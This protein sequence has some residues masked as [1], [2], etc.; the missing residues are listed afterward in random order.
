MLNRHDYKMLPDEIRTACREGRHHGPTAHLAPGFVQ[1]NL[2]IVP[3]AFAEDFAGFCAANAKACPLLERLAPGSPFTKR[4]AAHADVR[5]DLPGYRIFTRGERSDVDNIRDRFT[6]DATAFLLGCSFSFEEGLKEAGIGVRHVELGCNVPM[7][8]TTRDVHGVGPFCG[9]HVVSMRPIPEALLERAY[10]AT[11]PYA[12]VHGEPV[13]HGDPNALGIADLAD[14]DYGDAVPLYPGEVPVFWACGVTSQEAVEGAVNRGE[15]P[16]AI[17]HQP[18][19][20][21][22]G[23]LCVETLKIL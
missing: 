5:C 9:K 3:E 15:L 13:H 10:A 21:F 22:V 6:A 16:W 2:V 20:M 17:T 7:Y 23:D 18:G 8:R 14:P 19:M 12:A 1:A 4:L 11:R